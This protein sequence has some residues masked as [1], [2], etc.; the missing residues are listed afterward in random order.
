CKDEFQR[1][2]LTTLQHVSFRA[3]QDIWS[4]RIDHQSGSCF[5]SPPNDQLP[6]GYFKSL[7]SLVSRLLSVGENGGDACVR[8]RAREIMWMEARRGEGKQ[9]KVSEWQA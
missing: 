5:A 3:Q 9:K 6:A 1:T 2:T 4:P 8:V 7:L